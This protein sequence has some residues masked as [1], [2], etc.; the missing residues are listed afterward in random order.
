M[1]YFWIIFGLFIG[2]FFVQIFGLFHHGGEDIFL[3]KNGQKR[4]GEAGA[5]GGTLYKIDQIEKLVQI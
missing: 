5:N 1:A 2:L 4:P 3:M